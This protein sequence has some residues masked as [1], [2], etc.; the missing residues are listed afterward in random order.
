[1]KIELFTREKGCPAC[2]SAKEYLKRRFPSIPYT[3]AFPDTDA[4]AMQTLMVM[5]CKS[6]PVLTLRDDRGNLIM[7]V[8]G[9]VPNKIDEL[10]ARVETR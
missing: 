5:R 6:V 8:D 1:M 4:D 3:E 10:M 7:K 9:F 2:R